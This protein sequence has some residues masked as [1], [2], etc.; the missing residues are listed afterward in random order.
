MLFET[1]IFRHGYEEEQIQKLR[2]EQAEIHIAYTIL[3][4]RE[5]LE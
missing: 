4:Q 3:K 5:R 1:C 2:Y